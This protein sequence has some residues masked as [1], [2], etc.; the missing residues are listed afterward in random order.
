MKPKARNLGI[1]GTGPQEAPD[2]K[3][4]YDPYY[5]TLPVRGR[6]LT[7][8]LIKKD[9]HRSGTVEI[10]SKKYIPKYERYELR[11]KRIR[12]HNP[13]SVNAGIGERVM[14]I[15]TRPI[16][17]T[18]KFVI[19][20]KFGQDT[21]FIE[22]KENVEIDQALHARQKATTIDKEKEE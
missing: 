11:R 17:K 21:K 14:C 12:V 8:T 19:I 9:V 5:G 6:I 22:K 3:D 20:K 7:G 16:S 10:T 4:K 18:K 1:P 15:E 13:A 2:L